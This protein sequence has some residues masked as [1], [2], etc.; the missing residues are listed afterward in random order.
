MGKI[1]I[2]ILGPG[3]IGSDLA[4][5]LL[6]DPD[7]E[8]VAIVGRNKQSNGLER[9]K[10][11]IP[12]V[13]SDGLISFQNDFDLV[14]GFF[15][16]TSAESSKENWEF[17]Q[18]NNKWFIDLT[19]S[20]IG[21]AF[22]PNISG[23]VPGIEISTEYSH[24]YSMVTCGGQSSAPVIHAMVSKMSDVDMVE[25]SSSIA[26]NSAGIATRRNLD[27]YIETTEDLLIKISGSHSSKAILVLNPSSPEV[28]MRT[29]VTVRGAGAKLLEICDQV[30][31][32]V[33]KMQRVVPG[34]ELV[35]DIQEVD[36][37]TYSATI[38]VSGAGYFL[39]RYAGNLD[40][41]NAAAVATARMHANFHSISGTK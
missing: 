39:P 13:M 8:V 3:N 22:I 25:V 41:I 21:T 1:R 32:A 12:H 14:D 18:C 30:N 15:D 19:P 34:Y 23:E 40:I 9:F 4:E 24:N 2:A 28:P 36:R 16:A 7:F 20:R 26:A 35:G 31:L 27:K 6:R 29:T 10:N 33:L 17:A 11:R 5:R 38:R 37:E